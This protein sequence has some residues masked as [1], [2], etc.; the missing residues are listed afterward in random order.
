[1]LEVEPVLKVIFYLDL[2]QSTTITQKD[3]RLT[4]SKHMDLMDINKKT[5]MFMLFA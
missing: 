4:V 5:V 1:L 2:S 3:G